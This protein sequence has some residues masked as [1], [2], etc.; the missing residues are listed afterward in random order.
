MFSG[1][2][3]FFLTSIN[4]TVTKI[5]MN[6]DSDYFKENFSKIGFKNK[7]LSKKILFHLKTELK[8]LKKL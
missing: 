5:T 4:A 3:V 2:K 8:R 6:K 1:Y 7:N